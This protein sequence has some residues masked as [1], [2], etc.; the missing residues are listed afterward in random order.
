MKERDAAATEVA[1]PLPKKRSHSWLT[2]AMITTVSWGVWGALIEIPEKAGFPATLG[3]CVWALT[4]IIPSFFALK[5]NHW[6][7]ETNRRAVSSGLIIGFLGSVGQIVL[8]HVLI[9]GPAYLVFPIISLAPLLTILMSYFLLKERTSTRSWIGIVLALVAIPLLSFQPASN[10]FHGYAWILLSLFVFA[11][12]GVQAY[13]MKTANTH[14]ETA[15]IFFYMTI[16]GIVLIP[17]ALAMTDFTREINW[18]PSGPYLATVIQSL[19]AVGALFLVYA[20]R[21]GKAIIVSPMINA[22]APMITII[23]SLIIYATVPHFVIVVGMVMAITA[24]F[25]MAE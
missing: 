4:M 7:L 14:M 19:N 15:S 11:A 20:F 21:Y 16:T 24:I 22:G 12:W 3:Y 9:I 10:G 5:N 8:F 23:L 13:F 17:V 2:Y 1:T 6:K 25:L 18:G